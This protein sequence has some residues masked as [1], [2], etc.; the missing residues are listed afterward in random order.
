MAW[1]G[2]MRHN[3]AMCSATSASNPSHHPWGTPP[4]FRMEDLWLVL[5]TVYESRPVWR[6]APFTIEEGKETPRDMEAEISSAISSLLLKLKKDK[7][8][9]ELERFIA[10][11]LMKRSHQPM[12]LPAVPIELVAQGSFEDYLHPELIDLL[13]QELA[14]ALTTR[15]LQGV[16]SSLAVQAELVPYSREPKGERGERYASLQEASRFLAK[17]PKYQNPNGVVE[18]ERTQTVIG[19][20]IWNPSLMPILVPQWGIRNLL[21]YQGPLSLQKVSFAEAAIVKLLPT[22]WG[23]IDLADAKIYPLVS[24]PLQEIG[25]PP[26]AQLIHTAAAGYPADSQAQRGLQELG[27]IPEDDREWWTLAEFFDPIPPPR[28]TTAPPAG[29]LPTTG[30]SGSTSNKNISTLPNTTS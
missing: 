29:A 6:M 26:N 13:S 9:A 23:R 12:T 25:W 21:T 8:H 18:G 3:V 2:G 4:N 22:R 17:V 15:A 16:R 14:P 30:S 24:L 10:G 27:D 5:A 19:R 1:F 28:P 20:T 11:T 7:E